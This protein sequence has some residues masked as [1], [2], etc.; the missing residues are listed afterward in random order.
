MS[1]TKG[2]ALAAYLGNFLKKGF[3]IEGKLSYQGG[4]ILTS[5]SGYRIDFPSHFQVIYVVASPLWPIWE[6]LSGQ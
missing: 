4:P 2:N 3:P 5:K 1:S 6:D